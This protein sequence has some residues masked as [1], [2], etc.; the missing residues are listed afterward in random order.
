MI[1]KRVCQGWPEPQPD[2]VTE[3]PFH[4]TVPPLPVRGARLGK[5]PP[6]G[7]VGVPPQT[8]TPWGR[9]LLTIHLGGFALTL[10]G[11]TQ[12]GTPGLFGESG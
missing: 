8:E 11:A 3:Y 10:G 6:V 2:C 7:F 4:V 1:C 9:R 12:P 5:Q